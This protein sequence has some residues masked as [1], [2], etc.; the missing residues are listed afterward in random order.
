[1]VGSVMLSVWKASK[2]T[3]AR[4]TYNVHFPT[5]YSDNE[6]FNLVQRAHQNTLEYMPAFLV[7]LLVGGLEMPMLC[8]IAG[9]VWILSRVLYA[10][11]CYSGDPK[12]RGEGAFGTLGLVVLLAS[13]VKFGLKLALTR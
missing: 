7:L 6:Q 13:A 10:Q 11:G 8:T 3:E 5:V 9:N 2:V 12:R 4:K 1:M